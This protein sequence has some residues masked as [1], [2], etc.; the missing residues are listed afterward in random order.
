MSKHPQKLK[1]RIDAVLPPVVPIP[2]K[3]D[4]GTIMKTIPHYRRCPVCWEGNGGFGD[5]QSTQGRTRYYKCV[6]TTKADGAGP[7]GW[8]WTA[9]V[10]LESVKIEHRIVTLDGER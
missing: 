6:Q 3:S 5:C 8:T 2:V 10:L 7:C 1:P 4:G 9:T